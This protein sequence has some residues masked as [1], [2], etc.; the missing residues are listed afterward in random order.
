MKGKAHKLMSQSAGVA[1]YTDCISAE[2]YDFPNDC[3]GY[4]TKQSD[5]EFCGMWC[6]SSLPSLPVP[7]KPGVVTT[8]L[9]CVFILNGIIRNRCL[10]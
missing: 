1:E 8:E 9:N 10:T 3:P 5:G 6:P 4:D 2:D 7:T